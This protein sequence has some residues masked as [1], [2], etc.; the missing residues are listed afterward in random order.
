[1]KI[2][3]SSRQNASVM[4]VLVALPITLFFNP[5]AAK[6]QGNYTASGTGQTLN[7]GGSEMTD[8]VGQLEYNGLLLLLVG[9]I[10]FMGLVWICYVVKECAQLNKPQK[11]GGKHFIALW[12]LVAGVSVFCGSCTVEQRAR[13]AEYRAAQAAENRSCP[14]RYHHVNSEN[15]ALNNRYPYNGYSNWQAP[16]FCNYC[17]QRVFKSR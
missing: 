12:M 4:P 13:A 2:L 8:I 14:S 5:A 9:A 6:A 10:V 17:G 1:M 7:L 15:A 16:A 3:F 11:N